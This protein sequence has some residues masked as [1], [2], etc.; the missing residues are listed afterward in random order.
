MAVPGRIPRSVG[1]LL[2]FVV[3]SAV[4]LQ[5][6]CGTAIDSQI[7]VTGSFVDPSYRDAAEV[8]RAYIANEMEQKGLPAVSIA[9]IDDQQVVWAEG[10]GFADPAVGAAATA[11]TVYRVGSV[12]KL[13]TDIAIMQRVEAGELDLDAPITDYLPGFSPSNSFNTPIR[14]WLPRSPASMKPRWFSRPSRESST[15]TLPSRWLAM[16][17]RSWKAS[18]SQPFCSEM[19]WIR[20]G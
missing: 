8:L 4:L 5:P 10:F 9:L 11:E 20:W 14:A 18:R 7:G 6:G 19:F 17:W 1:L 16:C 13:F 15:P 3:L 12:S 2:F